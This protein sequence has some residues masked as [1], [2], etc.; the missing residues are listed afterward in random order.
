[1]PR[2]TRWFVRAALAYFL[3]AL[4]VGL[5]LALPA[6]IALPPWA[7]ALSPVYFHLL[8]VGW[9]TELIFGVMYWMFPKYSQEQPRGRE[10]LA[11]V[12]FT[13]LNAG[14]LLRAISEPAHVVSSAMIWGWLLAASAL[15]QWLGGVAFAAS[16]WP[17]VKER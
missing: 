8:L 9:L 6:N 10:W 1:M 7:R 2:L 11:W 13:C 15:L 3:L 5:I 16:I 14:L 12:A 4:V 17:R